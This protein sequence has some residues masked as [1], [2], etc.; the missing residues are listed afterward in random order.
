MVSI[1]GYSSAGVVAY[2]VWRLLRGYFVRSPLDNIPGPPPTS[3]IAGDM[4]QL[5][6]QEHWDFV[7]KICDTYGA[8]AK[9]HGPLGD[10]FLHVYDPKALHSIF[11]KDQE[12]YYKGPEAVAAMELLIG[13]GLLA[14]YG[15]P[16][17]KQRK[18]LNPVFSVAHMRNLTPL[19]YSIADKLRIAIET[20]VKDGPQ[21]LDVLTWMGRT[22]LELVGQ[23]GLGHSFD[24]LVEDSQDEFAEAVKAYVPS[25]NEVL[26][27]MLFFPYV[28]YMGPAWFRSMVANVFPIKSVRRMKRV[29]D[30]VMKH[31][32]KLLDAK[33][34]AVVREDQEL[35]H[36]VAEGKDVMSILLRS[37]MDATE[38]D[39]LPGDEL[40]AQMATFIIAGVDTTS[41]AMSRI[42]HLLSEHQDVQDRL[43]EEIQD[44]REQY[45]EE[46]PYDELSQLPYL[47]AVCRETLRLYAPLTLSNRQYETS[48]FCIFNDSPNTH[49]DVIELSTIPYFRFLNQSAASTER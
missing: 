17:K 41:N 6:G 10:Q 18:M 32:Q 24:P 27:A 33:K 44:A 26:W 35:M 43:R 48:V 23:G 14:T 28:K 34:A 16:H 30:I 45:G 13:P 42:L 37:N 15:A 9:L 19:F 25:F 47:D 2:V 11:V 20:R 4:F 12:S 21:A 7:R 8:I 36:M 1:V 49:C 5:L 40:L 3:K 29:N 46:I 31:S 39:K 38:E 22:A